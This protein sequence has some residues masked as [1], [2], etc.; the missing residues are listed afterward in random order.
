LSNWKIARCDHP[1]QIV[2]SIALWSI[3]FVAGSA[4]AGR[5]GGMAHPHDQPAA[6]ARKE[7]NRMRSAPWFLSVLVLATS[8]QAAT[9]AV[10]QRFARRACAGCHAIGVSGTSPNPLAPPFR[11]LPARLGGDRLELRLQAISRHGHRA[12]PPIYMTPAE[13]RGVA[14]Y[15]RAVSTRSQDRRT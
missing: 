4:C 5:R 10:G 1:S 15:I 9:P 14:A 3:L 13:R 8:A 7:T 12:M 2:F 11:R 6:Q